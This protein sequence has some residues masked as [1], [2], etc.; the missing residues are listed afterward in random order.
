M[1]QIGSDLAKIFT[2]FATKEYGERS[3]MID[4]KNGERFGSNV[5][6]KMAKGVA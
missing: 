5:E 4:R 2:G 6:E 1:T 3:V